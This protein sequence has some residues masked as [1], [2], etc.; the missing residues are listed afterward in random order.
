MGRALFNFTQNTVHRL[1]TTYV[2]A[3]LYSFPCV[4]SFLTS[5][6]RR[7]F[8]TLRWPPVVFTPSL[9]LDLRSQTPH[10]F[11]L[12]PPSHCSVLN[13]PSTAS[14]PLTRSSSSFPFLL[15]LARPSLIPITF[16]YLSL[17]KSLVS[18]L[19]LLLLL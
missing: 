1:M 11:Y 17:A 19:H 18:S 13:T 4:T 2:F 3:L 16:S 15:L 14:S 7:P 5:L 8:L 10:F 9:L 6:S 12:C